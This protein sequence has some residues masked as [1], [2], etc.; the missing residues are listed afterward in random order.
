[1]DHLFQTILASTARTSHWTIMAPHLVPYLIML[2]NCFLFGF[3]RRLVTTKSP[4]FFLL[5]LSELVS[6][7]E[8]CVQCAELNIVYD[9]HGSWP[10]GITLFLLS[11]WWSCV[12]GEAHATPVYLFE[13]IVTASQW[14]WAS[15]Y[16]RLTGQ[17]LALPLAI[18]FAGVYWGKHLI[19]QHRHYDNVYANGQCQ[20][21]IQTSTINAFLVEFIC[22]L[23]YRLLELC[24]AKWQTNNQLVRLIEAA[25]G[26]ALVVAGE[27]CRNSQ[28]F[29][30]KKNPEYSQFSPYN[31]KYYYQYHDWQ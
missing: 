1:M 22:C 20:S 28:E 14:S 5:L 3:A 17:L 16:L 19:E 15:V 9:L 2:L 24:L 18:R 29:S 8:L 4:R 6:T 10:Y 7:L 26:S 21:A 31:S 25:I 30:R 12:F 23:L 13:D 11:I 27:Y